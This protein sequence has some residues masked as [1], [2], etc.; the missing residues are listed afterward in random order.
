[1]KRF[2]KTV[3]KGLVIAVTAP[4]Y[5]VSVSLVVL[6]LLILGHKPT[7]IMEWINASRGYLQEE[8]TNK[9]K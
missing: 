7:Q 6:S 3:L 9:A 5:A 4:M 1:M 8:S 2:M